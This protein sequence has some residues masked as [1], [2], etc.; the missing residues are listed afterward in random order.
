MKQYYAI[1]KLGT[2]EA[3]EEL[4]ENG[5]ENSTEYLKLCNVAPSDYISAKMDAIH[6]A[7]PVNITTESYIVLTNAEGIETNDVLESTEVHVAS[8]CRNA[9]F[10]V[11]FNAYK[12][13]DKLYVLADDFEE[14]LL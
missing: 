14:K 3:D 12:Y 5:F 11:Q 7:D 4:L 10:N 13:N 2:A 9:F 8:N 6:N 1:A